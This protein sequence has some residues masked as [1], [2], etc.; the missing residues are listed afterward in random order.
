MTVLIGNYIKPAQTTKVKELL[1]L[2]IILVYL[3][4]MLHTNDRTCENVRMTPT[5]YLNIE[6]L[7]IIMIKTPIGSLLHILDFMLINFN[8]PLLQQWIPQI[9]VFPRGDTPD[10]SWWC[11]RGSWEPEPALMNVPPCNTQST[12]LTWQWPSFPETRECLIPPYLTTMS[13]FQDSDTTCHP[14]GEVIWLSCVDK[15]HRPTNGQMRNSCCEL[16]RCL[17]KYHTEMLFQSL[18]RI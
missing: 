13:K 15:R 14:Q 12:C 11:A 17:Y 8:V 2:K 3:N 7:I 16:C 1:Q 9:E 5:E 18:D 10:T 6:Q 4:W